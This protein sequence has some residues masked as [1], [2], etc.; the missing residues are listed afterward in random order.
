MGARH[1][2]GWEDF[3]NLFLEISE[4]R[5]IKIEISDFNQWLAKGKKEI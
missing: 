4:N 1:S 2:R 5:N 3:S